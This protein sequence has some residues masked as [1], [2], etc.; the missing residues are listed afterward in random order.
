MI[1]ISSQQRSFFCNCFEHGFKAFLAGKVNRTLKNCFV[2][3][4]RKKKPSVQ[5]G[6]WDGILQDG[7]VFKA[8]ITLFDWLK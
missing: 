1:T 4:K 6:G 3:F 8:K 5:H 2:F 7:D